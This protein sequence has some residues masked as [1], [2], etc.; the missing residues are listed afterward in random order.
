MLW[1]SG[2][3]G[4]TFFLLLPPGALLVASVFIGRLLGPSIVENFLIA[5][6]AASASIGLGCLF[7]E[8][9]RALVLAQAHR[10]RI[11]SGGLTN[12]VKPSPPV[13]ANPQK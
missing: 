10:A 12:R 11:F 13:N 3:K 1:L 5:A 2:M 6:F 9:W 7:S 4:G 8:D